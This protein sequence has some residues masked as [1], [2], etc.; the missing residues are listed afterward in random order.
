MSSPIPIG[1][2]VRM[3]RIGSP[4]IG[5]IRSYDCHYGVEF[6]EKLPGGLSQHNCGGAV[7]SN[8]GRWMYDYEFDV[9]VNEF[10]SKILAYIHRELG[11]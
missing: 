6:F 4:I 1:T 8:L 10:E 7:P 9:V 11:K 2:R 3:R 5:V